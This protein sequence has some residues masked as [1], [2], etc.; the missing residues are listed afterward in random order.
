MRYR[1]KVQC[2]LQQGDSVYVRD[3]G[4]RGTVVKTSSSPRSIIVIETNGSSIRRNRRDLIPTT[5]PLPTTD[6]DEVNLE[7]CVPDKHATQG[8]ASNSV[9]LSACSKL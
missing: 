5:G 9:K 1:T 2:Q 4:I 6:D 7:V 3:S 8:E